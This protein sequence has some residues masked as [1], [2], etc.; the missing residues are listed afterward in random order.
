MDSN[1]NQQP[2][3]VQLT[4]CEHVRLRP[5]MYIGG[6]T[7]S[8][9][10]HHFL[11]VII[12]QMAADALAGCCTDI[13]VELLEE[14]WI[15]IRDNSDGLP[16][17]PYRD[18]ERTKMEAILQD[19]GCSKGGF[20][21][22]HYPYIRGRS[23]LNI[24]VANALCSE[25][26]VQNDRDGFRWKQTYQAGLPHTTLTK[27]PLEDPQQTGTS[28]LFHADATIFQQTTFEYEQLAR[29]AQELAYLI[30][31]LQVSVHDRRIGQEQ[32]RTFHYPEGLKAWPIDQVPASK[33]V[34]SPI[35][36]QRQLDLSWKNGTVSKLGIEVAIQ[37]CKS[38]TSQVVSYA[39]TMRTP[40]G[41]THEDAVQQGI[42]SGLNERAKNFSEFQTVDQ[43]QWP[44]VQRTLCAAISVYYPYPMFLS[45]MKY[46]LA[47]EEVRES[48]PMRKSVSQSN[49]LSVRRW[50]HS[51]K[52]RCATC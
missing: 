25:M 34:C 29:R 42:L 17:S 45:A 15:V 27:M 49:A 6:T 32:S 47:N 23:G 37:F 51:L 40:G 4:P 20:D 43:V 50:S 39:N 48:L 24:Y 9:A 36:I 26:Q 35:H 28:F 21:P 7:D 30:G 44:H 18:T 46:Q 12:D 13:A 14:D 19:I 33:R 16:V 5:A 31:G 1:A 3:I 11:D 10:L 22:D 52:L 41:G 2:Q 38:E 8:P